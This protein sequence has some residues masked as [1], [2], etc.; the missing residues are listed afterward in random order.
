MKS[1]DDT[2][3]PIVCLFAE[4]R[5]YVEVFGSCFSEYQSKYFVTVMLGLIECEDR[6]TMT[7][8]QRTVGE[9][10]SLLGPSPFQNK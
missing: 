1:Q 9:R 2:H 3:K 4:L 6:R 7:G 5:Q 8:L 10:L